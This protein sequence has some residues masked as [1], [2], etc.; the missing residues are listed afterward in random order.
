MIVKV[1]K[2]FLETVMA[3]VN[4]IRTKRLIADG[5]ISS[6]LSDEEVASLMESK[7]EFKVD[8]EY[9]FAFIMH[10]FSATSPQST[11]YYVE[12]KPKSQAVELL[13]RQVL[14]RINGVEK[15]ASL[16]NGDVPKFVVT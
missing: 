16:V 8:Y 12:I 15:F 1:N 6:K 11:G 13:P 5:R 7:N 14:E 4:E 10:D 3:D 2:N 9:P